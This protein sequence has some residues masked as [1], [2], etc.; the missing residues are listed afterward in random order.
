MAKNHNKK[1]NI[2]IIYEQIINFVCKSLMENDNQNAEKAINIIKNHFKKNSQ[3][4]KEYKLFKALSETQNIS[5]TLATSIIKE[6]KK[7]CNHMFENKKLE[8]EKSFLIKD[9]NY[10]FGKGII[11]EEKVKDFRRYATIQT[12]LNEW[13]SDTPSFDIIT[14]YEVKLHENLISKKEVIQEN[15]VPKKVDKLTYKIMNEMFNKKYN[16]KL[17]NIQRETI[18]FFMKDDEKSLQEKYKFIKSSSINLLEK[19]IKD[20]NN[21][22]LLEKYNNV[23]SNILSLDCSNMSKEN[24][25]RFLTIGKLKEEILG[26]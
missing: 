13:R 26:D 17:N 23:K 20:C 8:E 21:K 12:L 16:S 15:F 14:E 18:T 3:L 19:Y 2:G 9:L 11:F 6:A 25:Q 7:A 22:I 24:L 5:E 10:S 4:Y 1:R